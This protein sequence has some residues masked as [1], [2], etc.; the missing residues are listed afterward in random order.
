VS[1]S[2]SLHADEAARAVLEKGKQLAATKLAAHKN[3]TV[4]VYTVDLEDALC[5]VDTYCGKL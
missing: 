2:A 5:E 4:L 1:T 3:Q